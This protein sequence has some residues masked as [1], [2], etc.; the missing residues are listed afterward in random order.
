MPLPGNYERD[1]DCN[2]AAIGGGLHDGKY[3]L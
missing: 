3:D 1:T 2:P